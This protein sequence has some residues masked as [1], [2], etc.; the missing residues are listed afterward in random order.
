M[1]FAGY[2]TQILLCNRCKFG[3][4]NYCNSRDNEFFLGITFLARPVNECIILRLRTR[5]CMQ[6]LVNGIALFCSV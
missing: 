5:I 1:K 2:V 3:E 6:L 4:K